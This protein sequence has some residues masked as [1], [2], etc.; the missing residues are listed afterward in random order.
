MIS[1]L[2]R[3][4]SN[5]HALKSNSTVEQRKSLP[6]TVVSSSSSSCAS[7]SSSSSKPPASTTTKKNTSMV[8]D[9]EAEDLEKLYMEL[10]AKQSVEKRKK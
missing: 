8:T 7:S 10:K 5:D 3:S 9:R 6:S 2:N 4:H 1:K